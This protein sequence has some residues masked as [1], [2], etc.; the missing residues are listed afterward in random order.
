MAD[1]GCPRD[2]TSQSGMN[3]WVSGEGAIDTSAN[4]T[5]GLCKAGE[6]VSRE[7]TT[8]RE[9]IHG[10]LLFQASARNLVW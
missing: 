2:V 9:I 7:A 1:P 5:Q 3:V 8:H 10:A 6:T 4:S